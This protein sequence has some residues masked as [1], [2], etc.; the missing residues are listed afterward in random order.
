MTTITRETEVTIRAKVFSG[1]PIQSVRVLVP[2]D[3]VLPLT[4]AVVSQQVR[5]WD[6][7]AGYFT[8]CHSLGKAAV[9]R[10]RELA[11]ESQ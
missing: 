3:C 9:R 6:D 2:V 1:Q 7:V 8:T 5:V 4:R 11:S 10:A